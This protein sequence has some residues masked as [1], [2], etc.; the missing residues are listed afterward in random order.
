[1]PM[2]ETYLRLLVNELQPKGVAFK[3]GLRNDE[4]SRIER[5]YEFRFP[6]DL[7][8]FLQFA[9]P[10]S[11]GFPNWRAG[12]IGQPIIEWEYQTQIVV[13]HNLAPIPFQLA[14][15]ADGICF[16]IERNGFWTDD[17]VLVKRDPLQ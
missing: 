4:I 9:L 5:D 17:C 13:G 12:W 6:P 14:Q 2:G 11:E 1:M 7:R 16:D 10:I 15:P 3:A 8:E